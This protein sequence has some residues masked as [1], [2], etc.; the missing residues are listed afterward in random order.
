MGISEV[1]R[2]AVGAPE[3]SAYSTSVGPLA[4]MFLE[5]QTSTA[6]LVPLS[7][8]HLVLSCPLPPQGCVSF[9]DK[10][11]CIFVSL[12]PSKHWE[13]C[14]SCLKQIIKVGLFVFNR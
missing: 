6:L 2:G 7:C 8:S 13:P 3:S 12:I 10:D 9:L 1:G 5:A 4:T 11:A 14:F